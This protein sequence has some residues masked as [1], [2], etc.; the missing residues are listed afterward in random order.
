MKLAFFWRGLH[1]F[2]KNLF[3]FVQPVTAKF[4]CTMR[5][6]A[7]CV[8]CNVWRLRH[9]YPD[10]LDTGKCLRVVD[11]AD[12]LGVVLIKF[13]GGEPLLRD[14]LGTLISHASD[15]GLTTIVTT[16]GIL[17]E[18]KIG[19]L[20]DLDR[21]EVSL[22]GP[23]GIHNSLRNID[24][25]DDI[26]R[27]I[28]VATDAGFDPVINMTVCTKNMDHLDEMVEL[29]EGIGCRLNVSP[30]E[31]I[32][33]DGFELSDARELTP[34]LKVFMKKARELK[35]RYHGIVGF[36]PE[37]TEMGIKGGFE[38][39]GFQCK[40]ADLML[41]IKPDGAI[42]L[43][44]G[45]YQVKKISLLDESYIDEWRSEETRE[46]QRRCGTYPF[47]SDCLVAGSYEGS[48]PAYPLKMLKEKG[49]IL[50]N[51]LKSAI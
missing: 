51:I 16:N 42:Q 20:C 25:F 29:A 8:F 44:C 19:E 40:I 41:N 24:A 28:E 2:F 31:I 3:G 38:K 22:D 7:E 30:I 27:G 47:C 35:S 32:P 13:T 18:E 10:D 9:L 15:L 45:L 39:S 23:R 4:E 11:A 14:D 50:A 37:F 12:E 46:I 17:L 6:N 1:V 21:L 49:E 48:L 34:D 36:K 43:P 33:F 5:C 26:L